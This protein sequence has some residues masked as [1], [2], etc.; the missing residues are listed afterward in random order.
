MYTLDADLS[1]RKKE[2]VTAFV[3]INLSNIHNVRLRKDTVV[4]FAE[5]DETEGETVYLEQIDTIPRHWVP[6][7]TGQT[8]A[9]R[10]PKSM[11]MQI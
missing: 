9:T 11:K 8:F 4:A 7:Q 10:L 3:L 6:K 2:T 1:K 5:K